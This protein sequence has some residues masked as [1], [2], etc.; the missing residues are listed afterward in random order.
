[1]LYINIYKNVIYTCYVFMIVT[2]KTLDIRYVEC[3]FLR[4]QH[5]TNHISWLNWRTTFGRR[6]PPQGTTKKFSFLG[7]DIKP[8]TLRKLLDMT[9]MFLSLLFE[10]S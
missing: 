7:Y 9:P 3:R 8:K 5:L 1:M 4:S 6:P 10:C 2:K